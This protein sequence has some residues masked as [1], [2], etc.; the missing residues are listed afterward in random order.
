[1]PQYVAGKPEGMTERGN[2]DLANR[3]T[4]HNPDGT[5]ST[6][7]SITIESDGK[8]IVI[9]TVSDDG[10]IMSD[11]EAIAEYRKTGKHLGKFDTEDHAIAYAQS[12]HE[13]QAGAYSGQLPYDQQQKIYETAQQ[14][15]KDLRE[16]RQKDPA[17]YA[18]T[19]SESVKNAY[20]DAG[21]DPAKVANAI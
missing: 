14:A 21:N 4:V 13:Q 18:A 11:D 17:G 10:R 1:E 6:V 20:T 2:I 15:D 19:Y 12:L 9:P 7:R 5:I 3:P 8:G 16:Q